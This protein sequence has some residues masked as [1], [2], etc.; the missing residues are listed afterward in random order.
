M[1]G[2]YF[3]PHFR[4]GS[5]QAYGADRGAVG[6]FNPHFR[7]GSDRKR[8]CWHGGWYNFNPHFRKGSDSVGR[9]VELLQAYFNPHFRKG[10]DGRMSISGQE[11]M[12]ISIH[13]SARE[14]TTNIL[15]NL[16]DFVFQSTL[17]QGKWLQRYFPTEDMAEFQ[18]TL[19]QGK[20]RNHKSCIYIRFPDFNPHFRKGSDFTIILSGS[21]STYF[22]PHF[23]KGSDEMQMVDFL[24]FCLFQSTLPQGKWRIKASQAGTALHFNPHFRKGSDLWHPTF[25]W[26]SH[27]FNPHFR[28]GSDRAIWDAGRTLADFN[29]HFRKGSDFADSTASAVSFISIHTSAREVT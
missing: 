2:K 28:K 12:R 27:Y 23:R 24:L 13:T 14:V 29:P 7:K 5:D 21:R 15:R 4:K 8:H 9:R 18:S 3:N 19:P 25:L 16:V 22:N 6:N 11:R 26:Y 17:P 1:P 20:W 10:S